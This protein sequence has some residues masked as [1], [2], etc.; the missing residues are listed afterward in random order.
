MKH[1]EDAVCGGPAMRSFRRP[2]HVLLLRVG[3]RGLPV[4]FKVATRRLVS[5]SPHFNYMYVTS[6]Q[7]R[8]YSFHSPLLKVHITM[9]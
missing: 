6:V 8:M 4:Y 3:P 5:Q 1:S 7:S 9:Q 2:R